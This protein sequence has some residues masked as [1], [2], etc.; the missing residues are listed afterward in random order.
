M[1]HADII[2]F[3]GNRAVEGDGSEIHSAIEGTVA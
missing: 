2:E 1:P 3:E